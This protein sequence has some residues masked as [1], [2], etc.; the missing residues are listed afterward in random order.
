MAA[1]LWGLASLGVVAL[2]LACSATLV[3]QPAGKSAT[4]LKP[5]TLSSAPSSSSAAPKSTPSSGKT[6][7]NDT[8]RRVL[9]N[10]DDLGTVVARIHAET[11]DT[12]LV[13]LPDGRLDE[14]SKKLSTPTDRPFVQLDKKALVERLKAS[15]AGF[16]VKTTNRFAY[17]YNTS[18]TFYTGTSRILETMYQPLYDYFKRMKVPVHDPDTLLVVLMFRT[19][20][21]FQDYRKMPQGVVAY[22]SQLDNRVAMYEHSA[23]SRVAP[24]I[25]VREA[26]ATVAHE[27]VHQILANI[28]VQQRLSRW[29][30]WIS[31]GLAE[32]FAP[33]DITSDVR[34]KGV[35]RINELRLLA[36]NKVMI[37]AVSARSGLSAN[38]SASKRDDAVDDLMAAIVGTDS[39]NATGYAC[40]WGL[41]HFLAEKRRVEFQNF[42]ADI[43]QMQPLDELSEEEKV[44]KFTRHFGTDLDALSKAFTAHVKALN[45]VQK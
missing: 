5:P 18:E 25:A 6:A 17:V 26:I 22:Y 41:T 34:W 33:T 3:A 39:L 32:Y 20:G 4:P 35:G 13:L 38:T 43:S 15:F 9:V 37:S 10:D 21:E 7:R 11:R 40:A 31:E 29:P 8:S 44:R 30:I 27:G 45:T 12:Y 28:G 2:G 36:L 24:E 16:R 19:D 42:L 23:L 14:K 1:K